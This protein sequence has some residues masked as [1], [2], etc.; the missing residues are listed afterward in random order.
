M[1]AFAGPDDG[2]VG[3]VKGVN[4]AIPVRGIK[5]TVGGNQRKT[6]PLSGKL[7]YRFGIALA[8]ARTAVADVEGPNLSRGKAERVAA[9]QGS[10]GDRRF[11]RLE[12]FE[13]LSERG[14]SEH[15]FP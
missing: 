10:C 2:A 4:A 11:F 6:R 8:P 13:N 14:Y 15:H 1:R 9:G 5:G 12:P 7:P 3:L